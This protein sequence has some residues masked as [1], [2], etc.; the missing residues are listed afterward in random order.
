[1]AFLRK[2][3]RALHIPHPAPCEGFPLWDSLRPSE[4]ERQAMEDVLGV[5]R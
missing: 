5:E 4:V 1:M 2:I 3:R